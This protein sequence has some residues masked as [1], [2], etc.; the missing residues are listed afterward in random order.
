MERDDFKLVKVGGIRSDNPW[1]FKDDD[2][3]LTVLYK[4]CENYQLSFDPKKVS[5]RQRR[6]VKGIVYLGK[7]ASGNHLFT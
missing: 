5:T 7:K 3:K 1:E 6:L 4:A 2:P